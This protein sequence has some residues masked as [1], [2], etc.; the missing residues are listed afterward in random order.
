M[1]AERWKDPPQFL[2]QMVLNPNFVASLPNYKDAVI[3]VAVEKAQGPE[4]E[5][6]ALN[7]NPNPFNPEVKLTAVIP[8]N[9]GARSFTLKVYNVAGRE[10]ADLTARVKSGQVVWNAAHMPSG[11]Y[12]VK[13]VCGPRTAFRQVTL[14]K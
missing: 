6:F 13:F 11:I 7:A 9:S 2:K 5:A 14:L 3:P 1:Q 4:D 10:V 8:A 12:V